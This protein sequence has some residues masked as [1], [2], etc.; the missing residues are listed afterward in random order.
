MYLVSDS[1]TS[2][3]TWW[4]NPFMITDCFGA[5]QWDL[6]DTETIFVQGVFALVKILILVA[7]SVY[8]WKVCQTD[9]AHHR[10]SMLGLEEAQG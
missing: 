1:G 9:R 2:V 8:T 5:K 4:S 3:D 7:I 6:S 10:T